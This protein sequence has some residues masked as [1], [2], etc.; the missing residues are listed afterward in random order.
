MLSN[1]NIEYILENNAYVV[2]PCNKSQDVQLIIMLS[3]NPLYKEFIDLMINKY[4]AVYEKCYIGNKKNLIIIKNV[5]ILLLLSEIYKDK[6][7]INQ[8]KQ[9]Y[10]LY[11]DYIKIYK[12]QYRYFNEQFFL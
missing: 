12:N 10:T 1:S 8:S 6:S 2:Y 3:E 7:I 11:H 9:E 4:N 5:D